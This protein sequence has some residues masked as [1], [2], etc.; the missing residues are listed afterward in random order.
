MTSTNRVG[1]ARVPRRELVPIGAGKTAIAPVSLTALCARI[2]WRSTLMLATLLLSVGTAT[3]QEPTPPPAPRPLVPPTASPSPDAPSPD[4]P[5]ADNVTPS[6]APTAEPSPEATPDEPVSVESVEEAADSEVVQPIGEAEP[7]PIDPLVQQQIQSEVDRA[8]SRLS[9]LL[10]ALVVFPV[11]A[12]LVIWLFR[13]SVANQ[14]MQEVKAQLGKEVPP[15][16]PPQTGGGLVKSDAADGMPPTL[17][18]KKDSTAQLNELISMALATQN[19]IAEAR[20]TLEDSMQM[21]DKMEEPFNEIFGIYVKQGNELFREGKYEESIE[22]YEKA[23][24]INPECYEAFLGQGVAFT[25]L[26]RYDEA[27]AAYNKAIRVNSDKADAWYGKARCYAFK[28]DLDLVIDNLKQAINLN[29]EIRE[30]AQH[31]S[32][33]NQLRETE[34]FDQLMRS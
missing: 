5:A 11:G 23:T 32:D 28:E 34:E 30:M 19:L 14:V 15:S 1:N 24:E 26:D 31:E 12:A 16:V 27:I 8:F 21:Q 22:I 2:G 7:V 10:I 6:P 29:P 18:E 17:P 4:A 9:V 20:S 33:F 25:K 3:A 13:K